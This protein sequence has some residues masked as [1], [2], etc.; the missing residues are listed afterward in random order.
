MR[1]AQNLANSFRCAGRGLWIAGRARNLLIMLAAFVVVVVLG[2]ICDLSATSWAVLLVCAGTV[3]TAEVLN[4]SIEALADSVQPEYD[5]D[6]RTVKDLAAGA[7][8]LAAGIAAV[9][10]VIV[11]WPYVMD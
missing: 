4:T 9:V 7:V 8:L 5:E 3:L 6:I 2:A 1:R 10:G 11:F